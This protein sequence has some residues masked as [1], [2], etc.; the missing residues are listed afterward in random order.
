MTL[1]NNYSSNSM[2]GNIFTYL[3]RLI[4]EARDP[5]VASTLIFMAS[6]AYLAGLNWFKSFDEKQLL[7]NQ[8]LIAEQLASWITLFGCLVLGFRTLVSRSNQSKQSSPEERESLQVSL[9]NS[10]MKLARLEKIIGQRDLDTVDSFSAPHFRAQSDTSEFPEKLAAAEA[11]YFEAKD[12]IARLEKNISELRLK[13]EESMQSP[14]ARIE[15]SQRITD[16]RELG[17][18]GEDEDQGERVM[19]VEE[20]ISTTASKKTD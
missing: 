3:Y 15:A 18:L 10:E 8:S 5:R 11:R 2:I 13:A 16:R 9:T 12:E 19:K 20:S 1:L 6:C 4:S 7:T 14:T 17:P